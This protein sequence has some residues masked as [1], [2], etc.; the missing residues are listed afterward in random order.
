MTTLAERLSAPGRATISG[1][2]DGRHALAIAEL[3]A[4]APGQDVIFIARDDARMSL[5]IA[6]LALFAPAL[7]PLVLPAWDC[8]PYDRVSPRADIAADRQRCLGALAARGEGER[9]LLATTVNAATQKLPPRA[10]LAGA[11]IAIRPGGALDTDALAKHL[12]ASG[13]RRVGAVLEPGEYAFRGGI[14]DLY[15]AGAPAPVRIDLFGDEVESLRT[16]DPLTQRSTGPCGGLELAPASEV[17]LDPGS[18]SRF[19]AGY[20]ALFG[21][22]S[23]DDALYEAISAGRRHPGME[24]WLPLFHER[25][26]TLFEYLPGAAILLDREAEA[27][28]AERRDQT[29]DHYLARLEGM[30]ARAMDTPPYKPVPPET[31]FLDAQA[32]EAALA[33]RPVGAFSPFQAPGGAGAFD[34]GARRAR[35]FAP[36]RETGDGAPYD[37][38]SAH[39]RAEAKAGRRAALACYS[40]G[41]R[42]RLAGLLRQH[43]APPIEAVDTWPQAEALPRGAVAAVVLGLEHGFAGAGISLLTEQDILGDRLAR[44]AARRRRA[45]D[46][47]AA[48]G[49]LADGDLAVHV[50]H[51][52]GRYAGLETI[53]AGDAPHDCLVLLYAGDDKLYLPVENIEMLS[54]YGGGGPAN[55]PLDRLGGASWQAR[56]ARMKNR[57]RDMA[58]ALIRTAA[59]RAL[60]A[61]A[62][63]SV[64]AALYDEFAAQFPWS[65][66]EDQ[67]R[68][69]AECLDDLGKSEPM[70]RLVCGDVGYGKTEVALR[71]AFVAALSGKQT[72]VVVPT[73]LLCR[74]HFATFRDRFK[75]LPVRVAQLSRLV[76]PKHAADMRKGIADATI[77]IAVGTHALLGKS[78][79]FADLGLLVI[80]EEQHFG[81]AQKERLKALKADVH[82]LTLSATP[83]P[84]TMQ[85]A[86][87]GVRSFS[88][89]ATP[90]VDRLAVRTFVLP[91]DPVTVREAILRERH[92]GGQ[93]FYVCPRIEDLDRVAA[94]IRRI[95]PDIRL[96]SAHGR[97]AAKRLEDAMT[98]FYDGRYELL[99]ST[100]IIESGLDMPRVNTLVV[101]R[102][103]MFGLAQ[104][105]QLRGRVGRSKTRAYAYFTVPSDRR[106]TRG[107][108]RRLEVIQALDALGAGFSLASHDLDIR[109]AGN[110]LGEEQSGHI[111]EVGVELYRQ[112]LEE[113]VQAARA[114]GGDAPEDR[115]SPQIALGIAVMIPEDYVG[116]LGVRL[117]LYRRL[118]DLET[119]AE[120]EAFAAEL[121]DRF[122]PLPAAAENLLAL[123]RIKRLCRA[124]GVER[125]DAGPRG[126]A[127]AFRGND[128]A[129]PE[130]LMKFIARDAGRMRVRPDRTLFAARDWARES[131]RLSGA[132]E[133]MTALAALAAG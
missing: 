66:T 90:P 106:L 116:D 74:Q 83:I 119:D 93:I 112:M 32:W 124:A 61:A 133:L 15:P 113:A 42:D 62:P 72:A 101:H 7:R 3:C 29:A 39:L 45:A 59:E 117:G 2:P 115:W 102:S 46:F 109:G 9:V 105:H 88:P 43:G 19:R 58:E 79:K 37:A 23:A 63:L 38:V 21:P 110:L 87:S 5:A 120:T 126:A 114:G 92:R 48:A 51:G 10:A 44:P 81:V 17:G 78:V 60:G 98:A 89:I 13:Y 82:V 4:A 73:T 97:M 8:L 86:L 91:Y 67:E 11:R 40:A 75:G 41:S 129:A 1:A 108:E 128:F 64:G 131:D 14:V 85:L 35:D 52:I 132:A 47:I 76:S 16:F 31:L 25:L 80:D 99:L 54:R 100:S 96:V 12:A 103:D 70:D 34:A 71:A 57:L 24:H 125:L 68:A 49:E 121:V 77:D 36:E 107:A 111:R 104:L 55:V 18:I 33:E 6:A 95:A 122:G 84:R 26:E 50:D 30:K 65:E 118:A 130:A 20:R 53:E 127:I 27:T 28:A 69:I 56:K 94:E 123:A 22:A